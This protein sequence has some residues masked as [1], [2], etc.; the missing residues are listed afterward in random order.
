MEKNNSIKEVCPTSTQKLIEKG[1]M[2]LDI[3]EKSE[4]ENL[5]FDVPKIVYIPLSELIE[6][7]DEIPKEEKIIVVCESGE[8][9]WRAVSFLQNLGFTNLVNMKNGLEKWVQKGF[10][11]IGDR[12]GIPQNSCCKSAHC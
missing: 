1:Y 5:A 4:V 8:R 6:R 9:S 12:T 2:L 7:Y 11:T 3:R 10:S